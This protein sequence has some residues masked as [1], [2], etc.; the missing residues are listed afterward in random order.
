M[1]GVPHLGGLADRGPDA[2]HQP[3]E[4]GPVHMPEPTNEAGPTVSPNAARPSVALVVP[5][6]NEAAHIAPFVERVEAALAPF[7]IDWYAEVIDDSNDDTPAIVRGLASRRAPLELIH[8]ADLKHGGPGGAARSGLA[9]AD[10]TVLCVIDA[11][12]QH[13]PEVL[14]EL[15]A[16]VLLGRAD[17]CVGSRY[18]REGS[19]AGLDSR[20]RRLGARASGALVRWLF[21]ATRLTTD[22][23]SGLFA[24]R[25]EVLDAVPLRPRGSRVLAEVLVRGHWRTIC[26][27]PYRFEAT[28][29][30]EAPPGA[31]A[32][33]GLAGELV[34]LLRLDPRLASAVRHKDRPGADRVAVRRRVGPV[35]V[36]L[37]RSPMEAPPTE[38]A[39]PSR[40]GGAA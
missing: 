9:R 5:T 18:R 1:D 38:P 11:D 32:A 16:P 35:H 29:D 26:D 33:F 4:Q 8:R 7:P 36:E 34:S 37:L 39:R 2:G 21:P 12:L 25:R 17:I 23:G 14:P 27:V 20:W 15:L 30:G 6:R 10:A 19:A 22:P 28:D 3:G 13:P 40:S 31:A 24:M